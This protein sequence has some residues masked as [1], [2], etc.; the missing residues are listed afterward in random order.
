MAVWIKTQ[1]RQNLIFSKLKQNFPETQANF[2]QNSIFRKFQLSLCSIY[3]PLYVTRDI[4]LGCLE[5]CAFQVRHLPWAVLIWAENGWNWLKMAA[6]QCPLS[7]NS[8]HFLPKPRQPKATVS[9]EVH[10]H[11]GSPSQC[12][13]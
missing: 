1:G 7:A 4:G 5:A 11:P 2:F 8:S 12:L 9:R 6:K 3:R 10:K 13:F